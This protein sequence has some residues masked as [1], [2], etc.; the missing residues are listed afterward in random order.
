LLSR[1]QKQPLQ[2]HSFS[3]LARQKQQQAGSMQLA[4]QDPAVVAAAV[5]EASCAAHKEW[6]DEWCSRWQQALSQQQQ[7]Q[8]VVQGSL[9]TLQGLGSLREPQLQLPAG[10]KQ[11]ASSSTQVHALPAGQK[12]YGLHPAATAAAGNTAGQGTNPIQPQLAA[13]TAGQEQLHGANSSVVHG[14]PARRQPRLPSF[15][16]QQQQQ[17]SL[18]A[19]NG[20]AGS[21]D[22]AACAA[23]SGSSWE[24]RPQPTT[25]AIETWP[26]S[27]A[28]CVDAADAVRG[29][30]RG[31]T[32]DKPFA[33]AAA[34][35]DDMT[36]V[37]SAA[38]RLLWHSPQVGR[39]ARLQPRQ[40][41]PSLLDTCGVQSSTPA[42]YPQ[43]VWA[44][45]AHWQQQQ[46]YNP[47][48]PDGGAAH[49]H[50]GL[51]QPSAGASLAVLP[52]DA[53]QWHQ[54]GVKLTNGGSPRQA[55][56]LLV[57]HDSPNAS[58]VSSQAPQQH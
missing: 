50:V 25:P 20:R 24:V 15:M 41:R 12:Q 51:S 22:T 32:G 16:Q 14:K 35:A 5:V 2:A 52:V 56:V 30:S 54:Q 17:P 1:Q 37:M 13:L 44:E 33:Y 36:A 53:A 47:V 45:Q 46:Q 48:K 40:L 8:V 55:E 26:M 34:G 11:Q 31:G 23:Y 49:V 29:V 43:D 28:M 10:Q 18:A 57:R 3:P 9:E 42:Q 38:H 7:Q 27:A 6:Q 39:R 19:A 58:Q 4:H 21:A